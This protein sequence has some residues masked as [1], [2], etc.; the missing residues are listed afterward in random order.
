M[1]IAQP[2]LW[3]EARHRLM[4]LAAQRFAAGQDA[5]RNQRVVGASDLGETDVPQSPSRIRVNGC[6]P[7]EL[8]QKVL[9]VRHA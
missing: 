1:I 8:A 6:S 4:D 5:L 9:V 7:P 2:D 3:C